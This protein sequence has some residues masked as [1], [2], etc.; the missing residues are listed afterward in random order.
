MLIE[1]TIRI[2]VPISFHIKKEEVKL[3]PSFPISDLLP[4]SITKLM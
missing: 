4:L 3:T 1:L 2:N